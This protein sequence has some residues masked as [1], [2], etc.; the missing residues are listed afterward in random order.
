MSSPY[1]SI[2][3]VSQQSSYDPNSNIDL[4]LNLNNEKLLPGCTLD[5]ECA[6]YQTGNV[7]VAADIDI[8]FDSLAGYHGVI[9]DIQTE[10]RQAGIV[11]KIDNYPRLV[12]TR[13]LATQS[14][15]NIGMQSDMSVEGRFP[16]DEMTTEYIRGSNPANRPVDDIPF[17]PVSL[18]LENILNAVD[19]PLSSAVT[20]QIRMR[21]RLAPN[22]EFLYGRAW[23]PLAGLAPNYK[24]RNLRLN[25]Q[26]I[27]DDGKLAPVQLTYYSGYRGVIESTNQNFSTFVPGACDSVHISCIK[28]SNE[29]SPE[30]NYLACAPPL[31]TP[32]GHTAAVP[33]YG[34]ER[35][36]YAVNDIDTALMGWTMQFRNEILING[37]RSFD[38]DYPKYG[39]LMDLMNKP[40]DPD[41]YVAGIPFGAPINFQQNKFAAEVQTS[42]NST[43][44]YTA[45]YFFFRL[46]TT[47]QA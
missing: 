45:I 35:L 19:A 26:T 10:F 21:I 5:F 44:N 27:P 6:V 7:P 16:T 4:V 41:G 31:G 18:K 14:R 42:I 15:D 13:A 24:V 1:R 43:G 32:P 3:P 33:S 20:G 34:I 17:M 12:K 36:D 25:Y 29:T 47:I 11:E 46:K 30:R 22:E 9:R 23:A 37:L 38:V 8:K 2:Y 39:R 28:V 40:L